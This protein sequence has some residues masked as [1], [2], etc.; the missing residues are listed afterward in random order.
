[1]EFEGKTALVTGGGQGIGAA[2][3][4][5]LVAAGANVVVADINGELLDGLEAELGEQ[6]VGE[7]ADCGVDA[8]IERAIETA[9]DRFG[10][11]DILVCGAIH[12]AKG[13]F[14]DVTEED[15]DMALAV[16]IKGYFLS[17][18]KAVPHFRARGGGKV[19]L[20]SSTFGFVGAPDFSVYCTTKGAVVNMTRTLALELAQ[21]NINVNA[22]APGPI[23]TEG[24]AAMIANDPTIE[25]HRT[26]GMPLRRFGTSDEVADSILFLASDQARYLHGHN[27]VVDGG[28]LAV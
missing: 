11:L 1:M 18:Q 10:G 7:V 27:L 26:A 15:L 9:V 14:L 20:I 12:R 8:D 17:V 28:Y 4:R 6:L 3:A 19:I 5:R 16:N 2:T 23:K 21:E 24:M 13:A 25:S 22:V